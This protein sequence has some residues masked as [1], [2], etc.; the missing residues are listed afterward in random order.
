MGLRKKKSSAK[1]KPVTDF[2]AAL[3]KARQETDHIFKQASQDENSNSS[4]SSSGN[5]TNIDDE[6]ISPRSKAAAWAWYQRG[7]GNYSNGS[8]EDVRNR[9]MVVVQRTSRFKAEALRVN[10]SYT[11]GDTIVKAHQKWDPNQSLFDS[12]EL[13]SVAKEL[14]KA[15][16]E[17]SAASITTN[18]NLVSLSCSSQNCKSGGGGGG[19]GRKYREALAARL[20]RFIPAPVLCL[21]EDDV[22]T[23]RTFKKSKSASSSLSSTSSNLVSNSSIS[24]DKSDNN[25]AISSK[26]SQ[27]LTFN[28][29]PVVEGRVD[30]AD[31]H[32]LKF[33]DEEGDGDELYHHRHEH[34]H[35]HLH[36]HHHHLG[37]RRE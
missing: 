19:G 33:R 23:K 9:A 10:G 27:L 22:A 5:N 30:D 25:N 17:A 32:L 20:S 8:P 13:L 7:G 11:A 28:P 16:K 18:R 15:L 24:S 26:F 2:G 6:K 14:D 1:K 31:G 21:S 36:H 37:G 29:S 34:F 3:A 12:F 4:N 35:H